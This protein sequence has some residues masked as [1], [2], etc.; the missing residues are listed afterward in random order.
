LVLQ[1]WVY[2]WNSL[3]CPSSRNLC[4]HLNIVSLEG[5]LFSLHSAMDF[6]FFVYIY[7]YFKG[8]LESRGTCVLLIACCTRS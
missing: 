6:F 2:K 5:I 3:L 7:C 1:A 8:I 4:K